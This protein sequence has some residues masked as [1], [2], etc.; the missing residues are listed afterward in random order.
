MTKNHTIFDLIEADH[1][2]VESLFAKLEKTTE[3]GA[4]T[5]EKLYSELRQEITLHSEAEEKAIYPLL[6][7]KEKTEEIAFESIEEHSI[8]KFLIQKLDK[9]SCDAKEW[10]A[11]ITA[12]K[13]VIEHHVEEEEEEDMFKKMKSTF[14]SEELSEMAMGFQKIKG[15]EPHVEAA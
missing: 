2:K 4:K 5:R 6:K 15:R 14:S 9:T 7:E 3:R 10:T 12:L 13:E 11:Q 8:V 1:R